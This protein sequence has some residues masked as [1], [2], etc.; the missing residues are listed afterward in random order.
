MTHLEQSWLVVDKGEDMNTFPSWAPE[1]EIDYF[2]W[3]PTDA[4]EIIHQEMLDE[5]VISDHRPLVIDVVVHHS[6]EKAQ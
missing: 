4:F 3:Q 2:M 6:A 1:R 5:P